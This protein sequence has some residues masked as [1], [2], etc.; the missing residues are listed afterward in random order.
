MTKYTVSAN[1]E[2]YRNATGGTLDPAHAVTLEKPD[3][4]ITDTK[5]NTIEICE[6]TAG[7]ESNIDKNHKIK[8]DIYAWMLT[9]I[10][11]MKPTLTSFEIGRRGLITQENKL[12]LKH[13]HTFCK[14]DNKPKIFV[15]NCSALS[16]N[17]SYLI[18]NCR[19]EPTFPSLGFFGAPFK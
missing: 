12:R 15:E 18:F 16:V 5:K 11:L 9:D 19:K 7:H 14:K 1:I 3:L 17:S 4:V 10:T 13:F 6:L 2:G 8:D